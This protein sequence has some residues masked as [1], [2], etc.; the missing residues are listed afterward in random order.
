MKSLRADQF[1]NFLFLVS[2]SLVNYNCEEENIS[3]NN[4]REMQLEIITA[5]QINFNWDATIYQHNS[6]WDY[7]SNNTT[8]IDSLANVL[9]NSVLPI[10]DMW[11]PN[12]DNFCMNMV[13][14]RAGSQIIIK[15][16]RHDSRIQDYGFQ[17]N[18]GEFPIGCFLSWR[19]YKFFYK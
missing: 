1:L 7:I 16:S 3:T 2:F 4:N 8:S 11:Y 12:E 13:P 14:I 5:Q 10:E 18:D 6:N 19:H 15:L 9:K 17:S